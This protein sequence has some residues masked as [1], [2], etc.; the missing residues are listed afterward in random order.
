MNSLPALIVVWA[1]C[2]GLFLMLLAYNSTITRYEENQLFLEDINAN[3]KQ[4]QTSIATKI[5]RILP[6]IRAT[7]ALS[8]V[9]TAL[10]IGIYTLDAWHK[11]Q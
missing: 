2:T 6:F 7:G 8:A 3:E 10:I 4:T 1:V 11:I 9:L 5:G